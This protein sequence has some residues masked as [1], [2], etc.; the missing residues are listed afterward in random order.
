MKKLLPLGFLI[1][2][3]FQ[4]TS[5]GQQYVR[6]VS[7]QPANPTT[8]DEVKVTARAST[9]NHGS[10]MYYSHYVTANAVYIDACYWKGD[11]TAP[12]TFTNTFNLGP[13]NAGNYTLYFSEYNN[14]IYP[15]CD[16]EIKQRIILTFNVQEPPPV[17]TVCDEEV[18]VFHIDLTG[19]PDSI[20][21]SPWIQ[22]QGK[23]CCNNSENLK[24]ISFFVTLDS[25][26]EA[27]KVNILGPSPGANAFQL[28]CQQEL[29]IGMS[30]CISDVGPHKISIC[31]LGDNTNLYEIYAIPKPSIATHYNLN[32]G[33][34]GT[35][36]TKGFKQSS[37]NWTSVLPGSVGQY[38][39]YLSCT[40]GCDSTS[41]NILQDIPSSI[42]YRVCGVS[43]S[44]CD[45]DTICFYTTVNI[46]P[47]LNV[48]I[49]PENPTIC[50]GMSSTTL[51]ATAIGGTPPYSY[52]WSTGQTTQSIDAVNG[53]YSVIVYDSSDNCPPTSSM[54]TVN[55]IDTIIKSF[56]GA[57][58]IICSSSYALNGSVQ[59]ATT[60]IWIGGQGS[61]SPGRTALNATYTATVAEINSGSV[62]LGL[63]TTGTGTCPTDTDYVSLSL[64]SV[65][66]SE[67]DG[68]DCNSFTINGQT[69]TS[70]GFYTQTLT[71][72]AGCDSL[73]AINLTI[74]ATDSAIATT[75][76][77]SYTLNGH[78]YSE[79][80][81]YTQILPNAAGCDSTITIQLTI[82]ETT[83]STIHIIT[84][85]SFELNGQVYTASG[86]F[87]QTLLNAI[88]C[89]STITLE[90]LIV[91]VDA[92]I[93]QDDVE[94]SANAHDASYQWIDCNTNE[95]I[96]WAT[97]R[98]FTATVNGSYAVMVTQNGCS[99]VSDCYEVTTVGT[100]ERFTD[101][102]IKFKIVPN[103]ATNTLTIYLQ[104]HNVSS[105][106]YQ[107]ELFDFKG[108]KVKVVSISGRSDKP[109]DLSD[110]AAGIYY[111]ALVKDN[112]I[113]TREKLVV[114]K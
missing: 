76:C 4:E 94:L 73:I 80:G 42:T 90:L 1:I 84:C 47:P 101:Q 16:P 31:G 32:E 56:A 97:N 25:L 37:I 22:R 63:V 113:I 44:G 50:Y 10:L 58:A 40:S 23:G 72:I 2:A 7:I 12:R 54:I 78:T 6:E 3:L 85:N 26:T 21:Q 61:F 91:I 83:D 55:K 103:P 49:I 59:G 66:A 13:L 102:N 92:T 107:I 43:E 45:T 69:Y 68:Y 114:V 46:N 74:A 70:S 79:S 15:E 27:V 18:P 20:W 105:S 109:I 82:T 87:T 64:A 57:D 14:F 67:I 99:E 62:T 19:N 5:F 28:N 65:S 30:A 34:E 81:L 71:N 35:I 24:C 8:D 41:V 110:V 33:C 53:T 39:S 36:V 38:N 89:D 52:L 11:A 17:P 98:F 111:C 93:T 104:E 86:T 95:P 29:P 77:N 51:S 112:A 48:S 106:D 9:P 60:G 75:V 100:A 88:G 96:A 108:N